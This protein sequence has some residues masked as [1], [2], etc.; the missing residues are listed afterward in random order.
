L[1]VSLE[2]DG[3]VGSDLSL[4]GMGMALEHLLGKGPPPSRLL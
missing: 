1:P 4:L 3:P 2:F